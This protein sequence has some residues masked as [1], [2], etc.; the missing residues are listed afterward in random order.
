[1]SQVGFEPTIPV[2]ERAKTVHAS[3]C[4]RQLKK[5]EQQNPAV[6]NNDHSTADGVEVVERRLNTSLLTDVMSTINVDEYQLK[7]IQMLKAA[8]K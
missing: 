4:D 1:M 2:F 6:W 8:L 7:M 3:D 5:L